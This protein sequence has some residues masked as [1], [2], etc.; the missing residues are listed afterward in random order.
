[1]SYEVMATSATPALVIYLIDLSISM[2]KPLGDK[3]R[4]EV[5]GDALQLAIRQMVNRSTKGTRVASRYQLAM[6]GYSD[7]VYDLFGGVKSVGDVARL[8]ASELKLFA[9]TDAAKAFREAEKL[10]KVELPQRQRCPAPLICHLTD[11]EYTG[12]DPEPVVRRIMQM[13]TLD[14]PVLVENI[15]ISDEILAEPVRTPTQWPGVLPTTRLSNEY[16]AKLRAISS[17]L[18]E[19]YR[20]MMRECGYRL[21]QGAVMLLPG[22]SPELVALGFQ[23]SAATRTV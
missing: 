8:G 6:Y 3:R 17:P 5:V 23:M 2:N 4:I 9:T 21:E 12:D 16:A 11:G 14:G 20:A 15:F 13:T 22:T 7:H 19:S 1:M 10:L 18:P